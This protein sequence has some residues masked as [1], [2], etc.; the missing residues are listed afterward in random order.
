MSWNAGFLHLGWSNTGH[1]YKLQRSGWR[2]ALQKGIWGCWSS[3]GWI[4]VGSVPCQPRG[5]TTCGGASKAAQP[6]GQ[7]RR[8]ACYIPHWCG[9]TSTWVCSSG[10]HNSRMWKSLNASSILVSAVPLW[11]QLIFKKGCLESL[12]FHFT[13][14]RIHD[15]DQKAKLALHKTLK[16]VQSRIK[17]NDISTSYLQT[18]LK[19]RPVAV[20]A[21]KKGKDTLLLTQA[22]LQTLL[23][24][25]NNKIPFLCTWAWVIHLRPMITAH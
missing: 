14:T 3:V 2:T 10:P 23:K 11:G 6:A 20:T 17:W 19:C 25:V 16:S 1:K 4:G 21:D 24:E 7:K 15:A 12:Q 8:L 9:L 5:Q 13:R 22:L 18:N